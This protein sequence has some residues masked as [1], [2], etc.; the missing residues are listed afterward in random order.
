MEFTGILFAFFYA[1]IIT[2]IF[3]LI[4][5]NTGPW[6]GF[7]IFFFLL[8][9]I[10]LG[11]GEW[12]APRGPVAWGY[13]WAPGLFAAIIFALL[14]AAA[15]PVSR[16]PRTLNKKKDTKKNTTTGQ[17]HEEEGTTAAAVVVIGI[18]F[19]IL[20]SV[21]ITAAVVGIIAS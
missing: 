17:I 21:L 5:R 14:I 11:A 8:F 10:A 15:T 4:F 7:W 2:G 9:F 16:S 13:Y 12:A 18:F 1:V 6:S 3:S 19:W 20:M